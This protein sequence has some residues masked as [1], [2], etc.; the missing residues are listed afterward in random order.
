M[1]YHILGQESGQLYL[2]F[3][4]FE[5]KCDNMVFS[6]AK[7]PFN[8]KM[9]LNNHKVDQVSFTKILGIW[10]TDDL[11]R[12]IQKQWDYMLVSICQKSYARMS[13]QTKLRYIGVKTKDLIEIYILY[14]RSLK[15]YCS[16]AFNSNLT[17]EQSEDKKNCLRVILE[18]NLI[19][20]TAA[21]EMSGLKIL[22]EHREQRCHKFALKCIQHP[23]NK[24]L[25][26]LNKS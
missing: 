15:Q 3:K 22:L 16:T 12:K 4:S 5:G 24:R 19:I 9:S 1:F 14:I 13:M 10:I 2:P 23:I 8:T 26:P 11:G 21:L 17:A 6:T 7:G 20:Y 25:F 18:E